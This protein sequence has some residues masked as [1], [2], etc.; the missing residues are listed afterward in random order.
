MGTAI[1]ER[2]AYTPF[3][4]FGRLVY[5]NFRAFTMEEIWNNN[6]DNISCIQEGEYKLVWVNSPKFGR[7]LAVVGG[8]VALQEDG[9]ANRAAILIHVANTIDDV[10]GCIGLG[11]SLGWIK[12]KWAIV[13]STATVKKFLEIVPA[14]GLNLTIKLIAHAKV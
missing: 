12:D 3:G 14:E 8:D 7:T 6:Q 2:F 4:T 9:K 1:L 13:N 5:G 11:S 10:E